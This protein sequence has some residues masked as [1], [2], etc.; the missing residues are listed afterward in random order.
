MGVPGG[1]CRG[2]G[3]SPFPDESLGRASMNSYT[4]QADLFLQSFKHHQQ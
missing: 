2:S 4:N 1:P 3:E